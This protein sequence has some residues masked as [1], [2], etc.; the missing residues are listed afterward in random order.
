MCDFYYLDERNSANHSREVDDYDPTQ[1]TREDQCPFP[2]VNLV[3][4]QYI[5]L[6]ISQ[7]F[8]LLKYIKKALISR[9]W[10]SK[11][12]NVTAIFFV[13]IFVININFFCIKI[14]RLGL[15]YLKN[16]FRSF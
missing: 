11:F 12:Q 3:F 13:T 7:H 9:Q 14:I 16:F 5:L 10:C 6:R 8:S 4:L 1:P 15:C 2:L